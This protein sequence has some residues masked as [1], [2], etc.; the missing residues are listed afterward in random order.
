MEDPKTEQQEEFYYSSNPTPLNEILGAA[1]GWLLRSGIGIVAFFV[2]LLIG[3]SMLFSYPDIIEAPVVVLAGN[4]PVNLVAVSNGKLERIFHQEGEYIQKGDLI[5]VVESPLFPDDVLWL[6]E[7]LLTD[8][9]QNPNKSTFSSGNLPRNIN[10]GP[11]QNPYNDWLKA[12]HDLQQFNE[13]NYHQQ[14]S[15]H[16]NT[17]LV[18]R[19]QLQQQTQK[20][21]ETFSQIYQLSA[22]NYRR[23]SALVAQNFIAPVDFER[24]YS[25][26]L[27]RRITLEDYQS[28]LINLDVQKN[29]I[30][31]ILLET[32]M[33]FTQRQSE[34]RMRVQSSFE[35][36]K[37]QLLLWEKN[38]AFV[39]PVNGELVFA[40]AWTQNQQINSGDQVFSVIPEEKGEFIARGGIPLQGSGKVKK[41]DRVNIRLSNYPYQ[42][43]GVLQGEVLHVSAI[44][45]GDHFPFQIRLNNQLK[46]TYNTNLGHHAMLDGVAQII[47][48]DISLF[49]RMMNPLRSLRKNR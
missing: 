46:T 39:A 3:G 12:L 29:D 35:N 4:P 26:F 5:A 28:Q 34:Y 8:S 32:Q 21:L 38:Y 7:T 47:T 10:L 13:L 30:R 42:E 41:G 14:K 23:D 45:A 20:Q 40:G 16:L 44:P 25:E 31:S 24:T 49:N 27:S 43:Y 19:T 37:S 33:D 36:L 15:A 1:P 48:E 2:F 9:T 17:Q 22:Q 18:E 11:L 6:R